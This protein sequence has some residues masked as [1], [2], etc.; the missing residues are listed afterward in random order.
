M[1]LSE[2]LKYHQSLAD[3]EMDGIAPSE[4]A[5]EAPVTNVQLTQIQELPHHEQQFTLAQDE[6]QRLQ[7]LWV[8]EPFAHV[9]A[10]MRDG[11]IIAKLGNR[12]MLRRYMRCTCSQRS[13]CSRAVSTGEG[14]QPHAKEHGA[15]ALMAAA[16][17][18]VVRIY[19][20]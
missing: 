3:W 20:V 12:L 18:G 17:A 13:Q 2:F 4:K 11:I 6:I 8:P 14:R 10:S 19:F 15:T 16:P 9:V 7:T 1:R 5:L